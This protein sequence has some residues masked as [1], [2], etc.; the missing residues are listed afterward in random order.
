MRRVPML[1]AGA[2]LLGK[3]VCQ[4]T[5]VGNYDACA[6]HGNDVLRRAA[7]LAD[8][9]NASQ[10]RTRRKRPANAGAIATPDVRVTTVCPAAFV[11][12]FVRHPPCCLCVQP[13][14][15]SRARRSVGAI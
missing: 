15:V 12:A 3:V 13:P 5:I 4:C 10:E 2:E 11:A 1:E 9:R 14:C 6:A 7:L 8:L